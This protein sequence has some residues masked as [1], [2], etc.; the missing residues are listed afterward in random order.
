MRMIG[1]SFRPNFQGETDP[2]EV[3]PGSG[4]VGLKLASKPVPS[5]IFSARRSIE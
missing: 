5:G 2:F 1:P 3:R 4:R